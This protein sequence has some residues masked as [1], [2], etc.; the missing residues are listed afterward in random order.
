MSVCLLDKAKR[1][2]TDRQILGYVRL[3]TKICKG[4][5]EEIYPNMKFEKFVCGVPPRGVGV[6][7]YI[8]RQRCQLWN[9]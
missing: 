6:I 2:G 8:A 4:K 3:G 9:I 7:S 5:V 1:N